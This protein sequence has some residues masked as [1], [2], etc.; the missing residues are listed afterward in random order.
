VAK[1]LETFLRLELFQ[2]RADRPTSPEEVAEVV[3]LL[4]ESP[5]RRRARHAPPKFRTSSG[6]WPVTDH[7]VHGEGVV[8]LDG[9]S[10]ELGRLKDP[11]ADRIQGSAVEQRV[12]APA[13]PQFLDAAVLVNDG[14]DDHGSFDPVLA[15]LLVIVRLSTE[16]LLGA[17]YLPDDLAQD[18]DGPQPLLAAKA[19]W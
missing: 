3:H 15:G 9:L 6:S 8:H 14:L 11:A 4:Q 7:E 2:E 17:G 16:D 12:N 19:S 18:F 13:E 5:D 1:P 10:V